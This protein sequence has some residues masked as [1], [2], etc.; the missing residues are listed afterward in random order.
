M[1]ITKKFSKCL[2]VL[3]CF[4]ESTSV[5][6][7]PDFC[8]SE[9]SAPRDFAHLGDSANPTSAQTAPSSTSWPIPGRRG[10]CAAHGGHADRLLRCR[11]LGASESFISPCCQRGHGPS[12]PSAPSPELSLGGPNG[13]KRAAERAAMTNAH[14]NRIFC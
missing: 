4:S 2:S 8:Y 5:K 3:F 6:P 11:S 14:S 13:P 12:A 9:F 7:W 1:N 10:R